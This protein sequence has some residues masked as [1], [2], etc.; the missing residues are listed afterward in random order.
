MPEQL[1]DRQ[2]LADFSMYER[3]SDPGGKMY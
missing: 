1:H 3:V 2:S